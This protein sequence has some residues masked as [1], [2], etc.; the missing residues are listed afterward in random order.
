MVDRK[1]LK[2]MIDRAREMMRSGARD[3]AQ[4]MLAQLRQMLENLQ[5]A[6]GQRS[7]ASRSSRWAIYRR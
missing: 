6:D 4:Q 5:A 7:R 3:A 1:D 2:S